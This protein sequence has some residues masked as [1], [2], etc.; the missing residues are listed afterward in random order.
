MKITSEIMKPANNT[1]QEST[2][3]ALACAKVTQ[4]V[5]GKG[6]LWSTNSRTLAITDCEVEDKDRDLI[7]SELLGFRKNKKP[8]T[9]TINGEI[10]LNSDGKGADVQRDDLYGRFP[11]AKDVLPDVPDDCISL[12]IDVS[13]LVELTEALVNKGEDLKVSLHFDA[14]TEHGS[15]IQ[16]VIVTTDHNDSIGVLMPMAADSKTDADRAQELQSVNAKISNCRHNWSESPEAIL[17]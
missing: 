16:P 7:P 6:K 11:N 8:R 14:K 1:C 17:A 4:G 15:V 5:D 3:Y 9:V 10:G 12:T 2:R 13:L